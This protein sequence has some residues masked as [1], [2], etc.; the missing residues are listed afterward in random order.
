MKKPALPPVLFF[1]WASLL[2][3]SGPALAA[4]TVRLELL[5]DARGAPLA[6]Q[7]WSQALGK[8]G[9]QNFRIQ[10]VK[11]PGKPAID[12]QG[13]EDR[14]V[15]VVTGVIL[16]R[17]EIELPGRRF[18]RTEIKQL[19]AWL[20]DLAEQGPVGMRPNRGVFG[21]T[22]DDAEKVLTEIAK[23]AGFDSQGMSRRAAI[24]KIAALLDPPLKIETRLA[25]A[26]G[27]AEVD[28]PLSGLSR[29]TALAYLLR[30]AGMGFAPKESDGKIAY[31]LVPL[32]DD[33]KCWPVGVEAESAREALPALFEFHN[34][35]VQNV[36]AAKAISS[37]AKLMDTPVLI[38]ANALAGQEIDPDKVLVSH[39]RSRTVYGIAL[40]KMLFQA[41][42]KYE[43]RLD[44]AG[45]PFLWITPIRPM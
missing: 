37:I 14:P 35:N 27:D 28:A 42:L 19:A 4:G 9:I 31:E 17:D 11:E 41:K 36:S 29:G 23:P 44:D 24:E 16:S 5:G 22:A 20:N 7:E 25:E 38:D 3:Y 12:I 8:A 15:Y 33:A 34:V 6:F 30:M 10:S 40:R 43:V 18:R 1:L 21:L 13:T 39:P 32:R 2:V 26:L 45:K